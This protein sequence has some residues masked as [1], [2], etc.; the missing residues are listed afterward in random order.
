MQSYETCLTDVKETG[1]R[2]HSLLVKWPL[3]QFNLYLVYAYLTL[4]CRTLPERCHFA[5]C[6]P[7][8]IECTRKQHTIAERFHMSFV[9]AMNLHEVATKGKLVCI[10]TDMERLLNAWRRF[11]SFCVM[12]SVICGSVPSWNQICISCLSR[13]FLVL[14]VQSEP[15]LV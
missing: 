3:S 8:H 1:L 10:L 15:V 14:L 13:W 4:S 11:D 9:G 7:L 12:Y 6:L 5:V 2:V